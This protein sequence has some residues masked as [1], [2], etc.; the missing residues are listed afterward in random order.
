MIA[1]AEPIRKSASRNGPTLL[2]LPALEA[3]AGANGTFI[4]TRKFIEGVR[5]YA[6]LW[7]GRVSVAIQRASGPADN[8]DQ[9]AVHPNDLPFALQWIDLRREPAELNAKISDAA[10]VLV[11][12][13]DRHVH[14][15]SECVRLGVPLV[16]ITEYSEQTRRQIVN[17]ETRNPVLRWRREQWTIKL[18]R[19]YEQAVRLAAGLQCN[20]T[21][22]YDAYRRLNP[23]ALLY[24]DTRV[25]AHE[26]ASSQTIGRRTEKMLAGGPLRLAFSGRLIPMKGVDHLPLV[27]AELKR[28]GVPFTL[29][30]CGDGALQDELRREFERRGLS[31]QVQM[32]GVLDFHSQ[33]LPFIASSVDLFVCGHRQGDPSCTYLETMSCGTPIAGYD[34][35]AFR[36]LVATSNVG[37]LSPLDQPELLARR[38]A[39]LHGHRSALAQGAFDSLAFAARHTF[40]KTMEARVEHLLRCA[41]IGR[42]MVAGGVA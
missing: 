4:L 41:R 34:N 31:N 33:L 20:G 24:F 32:R 26:L 27:A 10:V 13:V 6:K 40:E 7:P 14:L 1:V 2:L 39:D 25:R 30:I 3:N 19:D 28:L 11:S 22:T 29:S 42:A 35:E 16:Y 9:V 5:E 18:E 21:P 37:W 8:L 38:I 15:A 17:A 12:L 36:G 23:N